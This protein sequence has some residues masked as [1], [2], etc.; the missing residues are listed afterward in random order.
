[1]DILVYS[2]FTPTCFVKFFL[3]SCVRRCLGSYL[4]FFFFFLMI[5]LPPRSTLFPYTTLFRFRPPPSPAPLRPNDPEPKDDVPWVGRDR[6]STRLNPSHVKISYAVCCLKKK[7]GNEGLTKDLL[8]M[9]REGKGDEACDL[10]VKHLTEGKAQAGAVWD[11]VHL[12][13]GE[14][15]MSSKTNAAHRPV[16]SCSL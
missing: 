8:A 14:L 5:R 12:A 6:K 16:N 10:A 9:Q 13:A 1:M 2:R 4:I 7:K 15:V 11:A 3:S